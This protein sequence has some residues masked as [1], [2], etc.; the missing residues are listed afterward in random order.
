MARPPRILHPVSSLSGRLALLGFPN[1]L[2]T[3]NGGDFNGLEISVQVNSIPYRALW[4]LSEED[5]LY[6][7]FRLLDGN[8]QTRFSSLVQLRTREGTTHLVPAQGSAP[9]FHVT[10]PSEII[11]AHIAHLDYG[12]LPLVEASIALD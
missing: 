4:Y 10:T 6:W 5:P 9:L 7:A 3:T 11:A 2:V 8:G 12:L 1:R